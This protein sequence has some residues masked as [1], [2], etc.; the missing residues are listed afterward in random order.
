MTVLVFDNMAFVL[1]RSSLSF[2]LAWNSRKRNNIGFEGK[3]LYFENYADF[4]MDTN[5][6]LSALLMLRF[7]ME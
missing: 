1:F 5:V 3:D 7:V 4:H 6:I 2:A